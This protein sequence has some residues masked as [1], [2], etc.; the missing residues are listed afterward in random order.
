MGGLWAYVRVAT[1]PDHEQLSLLTA[2]YPAAAPLLP[3]GVA[4]LHLVHLAA[5][6]AA[7][8]VAT[9]AGCA[10]VRWWEHA[11][12]AALD[13]ASVRVG[14]LSLSLPRHFSVR[15]LFK[16]ADRMVA[17]HGAALAA[18]TLKPLAAAAE[19][20]LADTAGDTQS[21]P[22]P[23]PTQYDITTADTQVRLPTVLYPHV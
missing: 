23:A 6:H 12:R 20:M 16:W 11:A 15:D 18:R 3:A 19:A 14:E 5:G 22:A 13:A 1:P 8:H 4:A 21:V 2:A 9:G 10:P 17:L 7:G